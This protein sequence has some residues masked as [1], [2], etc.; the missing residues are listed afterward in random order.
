MVSVPFDSDLL[1]RL[2]GR[3]VLPL[4]L[5]ALAVWIKRSSRFNDTDRGWL[6]LLMLGCALIFWAL[7]V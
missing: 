4:A 6:A 7:G 1:V 3:L 5:V 2:L